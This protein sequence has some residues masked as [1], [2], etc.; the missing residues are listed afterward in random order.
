MCGI[1][2][3]VGHRA[4]IPLPLETLKHRGP[5]NSSSWTNGRNCTFGHRRL[6]ILDLDPRAN[7]PMCDPSGRYTL[8]FNGEIYNYE[9]LKRERLAHVEFRSTSDTEVLLYLW[10]KYGVDALQFLRGMF[11]FALWDDWTDTLYLVRD[12]L[13][14]KPLFY[15]I[16]EGEIAFASELCGLLPLLKRQPDLHVPALDLFLAYQFIP[17]PHS[18]YSG[19]HK[20]RPAH[21]GVWR[22]G[23]WQEIR[24]WELAFE[25][26]DTIAEED[27]LNL[28]E[29]RIRESVR[30]RLR[31]DVP[32][33][34]LLSGGVDSSLVAAMA[35]QE[36]G[37]TIKTFSVGF[38]EESFNELPFAQQ[39]AD[40]Y[41]TDHHVIM[42][43]EQAEDLFQN[44]IRRY[45]EPFGDKSA[46]PSMLVCREAAQNV[47][48]VLN[49]DGG[50]ELLAG[51]Q[52]YAVGAVKRGIGSWATAAA[53]LGRGLDRVSAYIGPDGGILRKARASIS[54]LSQVI[55]FD[56]FIQP[57]HECALYKP[58]VFEAVKAARRQYEWTL[59]HEVPLPR[60]LLNKMLCIDYRHYLANDLL[61]KMD[62]ASMAFSLEARSPLLDHRLF[63]FAARLPPDMKLRQGTAKYLLKKLAERY[64]P[65]EVIYRPK[66]GFSI[67]V[68][69]WVREKFSP[70]IQE[71]CH[72]PSHRLWDF[73]NPALVQA[74]LRA[75]MEQKQ[76]HGFR[77]WALLIL[78]EWLRQEKLSRESPLCNRRVSAEAG[79]R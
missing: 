58:D 49:G 9:E 14:K 31:S 11:A 37:R 7:Q 40:K 41:A 54:P 19:V 74:W 48:V 28:L 50:D 18:I 77:L 29:E 35:A 78:G 3:K 61:V 60:Q 36:Y 62:L 59:I 67:P 26:E 16:Q 65:A 73:C 5:D 8:I 57:R 56:Q 30:L 66:M 70:H 25:P 71:M 39:V 22:D 64:L 20:I 34:V 17:A 6:A 24:Y 13:G 4:P 68:S 79:R 12:R 47:K 32:V 27:A 2:G 75:H 46:L 10:T 63:E 23:A 45:G 43:S 69:R 1:L 33:G 55:H 44:M 51:Y 53:T 15:S 42:L 38:R 21:Y 72:T 76:D 52:K